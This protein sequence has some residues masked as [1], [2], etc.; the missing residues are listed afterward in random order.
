MCSILV[1]ISNL[2]L[3]LIYHVQIAISR[4]ENEFPYFSDCRER[5]LLTK[6]IDCCE[7]QDSDGFQDLIDAYEKITRF[8]Q[9]FITIFLRIKDRM[10]E[11]VGIC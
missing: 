6:L 1:L 9:W 7:K 3:C 11:D 10:G 8:D 2:I 4:Y 5:R